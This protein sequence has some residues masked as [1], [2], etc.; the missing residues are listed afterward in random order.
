M[1]IFCLGYVYDFL[2]NQ[3]IQ[4]DRPT[5]NLRTTE[6]LLS[7]DALFQL[8]L[9]HDLMID[10]FLVIQG[11]LLVSNF[12]EYANA[13]RNKL[14]ICIKMIAY[15]YLRYGIILMISILFFFG[16]YG[17]AS[18]GPLGLWANQNPFKACSTCLRFSI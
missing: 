1:L 5:E 3:K 12:F 13:E 14:K 15:Q 11:I 2:I 6:N 7:N 10:S 9:T 17:R 4:Y 18:H 8:G 16:F